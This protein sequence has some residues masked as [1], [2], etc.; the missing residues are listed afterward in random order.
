MANREFLEVEVITY[1]HKGLV[2]NFGTSHINL[3][4]EYVVSYV[5]LKLVTVILLQQ[6]PNNKTVLLKQIVKDNK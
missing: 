1:F 4:I 3:K 5:A 2:E 6:F